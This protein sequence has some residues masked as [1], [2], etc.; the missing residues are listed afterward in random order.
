MD[1]GEADPGDAGVRPDFHGP[2]GWLV[3]GGGRCGCAPPAGVARF[4]PS[5][6]IINVLNLAELQVF[7]GDDNIALGKTARQ[8]SEFE[9]SRLP[10]DRAV[11]GNTTGNDRTNSYA[12]TQM[13]L[14]EAW[15]EVDLG[16][17]QGIDRLV[18]WN[19]TEADYYTRMNHFR[20]RILDQSRQVVFEQ[21]IDD[22]PNPSREIDCRSLRVAGSA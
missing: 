4:R 11:D 3:P 13:G 7:R 17:E 21:V 1:C 22:A 10:A 14:K 6:P 18:V 5:D 9:R 16:S 20:V 2:G 12:H 8:S 19:R 15:W